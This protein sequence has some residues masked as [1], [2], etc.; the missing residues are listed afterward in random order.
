M[1]TSCKC[2]GCI[3][4]QA[5]QEAH[6]GR[7]G[8]LAQPGDWL[9]ELMEN[10]ELNKSSYNLSDSD[11]EEKAKEKETEKGEEI[12]SICYDIMGTTNITIT[13]CCHK[14][15]SSCIFRNLLRRLECPMC[16]VKLVTQDDEEEGVLAIVEYDDDEVDEWV[17]EE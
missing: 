9:D 4:N 16:R 5:N 14:F 17:E 12:C 1:N 7:G 11:D 6:M 3:D 13:E 8:C 2:R 10:D 15:H